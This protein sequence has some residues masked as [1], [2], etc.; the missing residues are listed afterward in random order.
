[1]VGPVGE[2]HPLGL[3]R[4]PEPSPVMLPPHSLQEQYTLREVCVARS[5]NTSQGLAKAPRTIS[6]QTPPVG[7]SESP[8][9]GRIDKP[10]V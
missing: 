7:V 9:F 4:D 3:P 5:H 8:L 6:R 1:M 10:E 2:P